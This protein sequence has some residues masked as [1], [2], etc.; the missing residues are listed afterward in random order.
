MLTYRVEES[1]WSAGIELQRVV[2]AGLSVFGFG[3]VAVEGDGDGQSCGLVAGEVSEL[4]LLLWL[5]WGGCSR[6]FLGS[7]LGCLAGSGGHF[8]FDLGLLL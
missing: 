6:I 2:V 7:L 1:E 8:G 5:P 3:I 4:G